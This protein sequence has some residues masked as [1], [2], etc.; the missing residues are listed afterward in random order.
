MSAVYNVF[1][2]RPSPTK[3]WYDD[4]LEDN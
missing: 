4:F 2:I 3:V 1:S